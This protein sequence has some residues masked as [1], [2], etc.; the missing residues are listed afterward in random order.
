M[1]RGD[2]ARAARPSKRRVQWGPRLMPGAVPRDAAPATE[3][4]AAPA[5]TSPPEPFALHAVN[6]SFTG[7]VLYEAYDNDGRPVLLM[8]VRADDAGEELEEW[9]R[10]WLETCRTARRARRKAPAAPARPRIALV[11]DAGGGR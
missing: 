7:E 3:P 4:V 11:I 10:E 2:S 6:L 9:I 8:R 5:G 1:N